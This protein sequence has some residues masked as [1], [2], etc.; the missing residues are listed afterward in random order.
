[1]KT[2][3]PN[4]V[5]VWKQ[6]EDV[7]APRLRLS[8]ID[9]AVYSHLLRHSLL[10]GKRRLR[11]SVIWLA[12]NLALSRT[13]VRNAVHRLDELR[14]LRIL[15]RSKA[16]HV[17]EMRLPE[18]IRAAPDRK[19]GPGGPAKLPRGTSLEET[20]FMKTFSLRRAIHARDG[21]RCFYCLRQ[22]P[23]R[24]HC[25][26]HVVPRARSGRNSYRNL[27]S[28]CMEC[29]SAKGDTPAPDFLRSLYR[30]GRLTAEEFAGRLRALRALAA[31]K[32]RPRV[33][34]PGDTASER[35]KARK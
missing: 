33:Y 18:E 9:R 16:G 27:V 15:E 3:K 30:D 25:L 10:E 11:F 6:F 23:G 1:M 8:V 29:N 13:P 4:A 17:V 34:S 20:D 26:D 28:C 12:R 22:T 14:A 2:K 31:G 21:R 5:H 19:T 7:L 24:M 32:L 35:S